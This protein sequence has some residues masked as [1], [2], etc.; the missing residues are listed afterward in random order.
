MAVTVGVRV[1]VGVGVMDGVGVV[2]RVNVGV[3][4]TGVPVVVGAANTLMDP[5]VEVTG[6]LRPALSLA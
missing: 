1:T 3:P 2:V 4:T 6:K 5:F